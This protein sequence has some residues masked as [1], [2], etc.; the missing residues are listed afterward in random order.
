MKQDPGFSGITGLMRDAND[1]ADGLL[2]QLPPSNEANR[3]LE[4]PAFSKSTHRANDTKKVDDLNE[5]YRQ[6]LAATIEIVRVLHGHMD[7]EMR[8]SE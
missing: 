8:V 5:V 2:H 1:E 6:T 7:I 3:L 4:L